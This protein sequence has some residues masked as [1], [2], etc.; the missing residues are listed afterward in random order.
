MPTEKDY[1]EQALKLY[2]WVCGRCAREFSGA[3]LR[4]LDSVLRE[5]TGLHVTIAED[6]LTCVALGTGRALE[7]EIYRGVLSTA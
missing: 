2:P 7:E 3:R 1:R 4:E 6:P 5:A